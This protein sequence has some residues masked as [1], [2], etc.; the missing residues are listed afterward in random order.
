MVYVPA[1]AV[2]AKVHHH[3]ITL[4]GTLTWEYQRAAARDAMAVLRGVHGVVKHDQPEAEGRDHA[5]R[6]EGEDHR[7]PGP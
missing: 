7:R 2:Q 3:V 6:G 5:H 4:S 1:G